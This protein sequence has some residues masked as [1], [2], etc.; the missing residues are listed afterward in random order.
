MEN[1]P[2]STPETTKHID[3]VFE[4][5]LA[6]ATKIIR[7]GHLHDR[8]KLLPPEKPGFDKYTPDLAKLKYGT[9][10]Y[11]ENKVKMAPFLGHHY[12]NNSHHPEH[13]KKF[14]DGMTLY[15]LVEYYADISASVSR[16]KDGNIF[17]SLRIHKKKYHMSDQLYNILKNTAKLDFRRE[18]A[19]GVE[20]YATEDLAKSASTVDEIVK[21]AP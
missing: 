1:V 6:F 10:A 8:T 9:K 14:H 12:K 18:P 7:R 21:E 13:F 4:R 5:L 16:G 11:E 2:D 17:K 15:D 3:A 20:G 19:P